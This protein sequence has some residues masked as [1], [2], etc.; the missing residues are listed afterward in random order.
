MVEAV[1]SKRDHRP[2]LAARNVVFH[3]TAI[4]VEPTCF[5]ISI[6]I[7]EFRIV[8]GI[9][10]IEKPPIVF[11]RPIWLY[12]LNSRPHDGMTR[13]AVG[14]FERLKIEALSLGILPEQLPILIK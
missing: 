10:D 14:H 2:G 11:A 1:E 9:L 5:R 4:G 6:P 7:Q 12:V 8:P 13:R 3:L